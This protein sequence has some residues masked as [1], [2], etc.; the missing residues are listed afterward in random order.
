LLLSTFRSLPFGSF[1]S[2]YINY[3]LFCLFNKYLFLT[4]FI[5]F[6]FQKILSILLHLLS[7]RRLFF[8][9]LLTISGI[10]LFLIVLISL[11]AYF[12]WLIFINIC[13]LIY[14]R[15]WWSFIKIRIYKSILNLLL[16]WFICLYFFII[17][18]TL[19]MK[20]LSIFWHL[21]IN[22]LR[23]FLAI[24]ISYLFFRWDFFYFRWL[25]EIL[26]V[27]ILICPLFS[28]SH[29]LLILKILFSSKLL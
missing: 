9:N 27:L 6:I 28:S 3:R 19:V 1:D 17:I 8:L 10:I 18:I 22:V 2:F 5:I 20:I 11:I 29:N 15:V 13:G 23:S 7:N 24:Y 16:S 4:I 26:S 21:I 14:S 25:Y 12:I